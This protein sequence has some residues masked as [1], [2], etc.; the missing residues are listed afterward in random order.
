LP[1]RDRAKTLLRG[2]GTSSPRAPGLSFESWEAFPSNESVIQVCHPDWRGV[3]TAA[4]AFRSPVVECDDLA[5]WSDEL[6]EQISRLSI[7]T[8]VIQGWPP[9]AGGFARRLSERG[10]K[11][12][13][14]V[15]SS[16]AQHGAEAGEANVADE[17]LSLGR[18]GTL[19][20]V[21]MVKSGVAEAFR[22]AGHPVVHV[23]N[24][25]PD[26]PPVTPIDLGP[27]LHV[28]VFA[29]PFWRKNVVTQLLSLSLLD[30]AVGHVLEKPS[31]GYLNDLEIVEH[32]ELP[33]PDFIVLQGSVDVNLYVTLTECHPLSPV[34]SYLLGVPCLLSRTSELFMDD[35]ELWDL[36]TTDAPD[37]P[38]GI[39]AATGRLLERKDEA[40]NRA[41]TWIS[42]ADL[43]ARDV[44]AEFVSS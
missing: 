5:Y 19:A 2:S 8:V 42:E 6:S 29:A 23:P 16:P 4:Y 14:V 11:V 13:C 30:E 15:H 24:R 34:E 35:E 12:K 1:L 31:V 9:G 36:T 20:G 32:G 17:V 10:M 40:L 38:V 27:G 37:Q 7:D 26:V 25:A 44:W 43:R 28:G 21:G 39:A 18:D 3:R 41:R 22:A 33:W